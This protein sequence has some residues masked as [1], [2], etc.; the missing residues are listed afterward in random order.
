MSWSKKVWRTQ[1]SR[2][3]FQLANIEFQ[4]NL[5]LNKIDGYV[6]DFGELI[7]D[8]DGC[9]IPDYLND[10]EKD[11][12][13]TNEE[14]IEFIKLS[15]LIDQTGEFNTPD[16]FEELWGSEI[17][18]KISNLA[19]D[20]YLNYFAKENSENNS[21]YTKWSQNWPLENEKPSE[22]R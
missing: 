21:I 2:N 1:V 15:K 16:E 4:K 9:G 6:G 3:L 8:Y 13:I 19:K 12:F 10:F 22:N 20:L 14:K 18:I 17:W 5:W 11:N 7:N